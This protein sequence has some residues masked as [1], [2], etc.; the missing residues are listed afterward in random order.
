V[1]LE[2]IM[3]MTGRKG[4][5][6]I[7]PSWVIYPTNDASSRSSSSTLPNKGKGTKEDRGDEPRKVILR[8]PSHQQLKHWRPP[9][10]E[11]EEKSF[12]RSIGAEESWER[13]RMSLKNKKVDQVITFDPHGTKERGKIPEAKNGLRSERT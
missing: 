8:P 1:K 12:K 13:Y 4:G 2:R 7:L 11:G 5:V 9:P 6:N 3:G 10:R